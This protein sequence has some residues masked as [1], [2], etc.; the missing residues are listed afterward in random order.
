FR[1]AGDRI[2]H[3]GTLND[4]PG[5]DHMGN[6]AR[7]LRA[8]PGTVEIDVDERKNTGTFIAR[9]KLPEGDYVLEL[10][11]FHEFS[12]CQDGGIVAYLHEHGDSGCGD[13]NWPK[14]FVYLAG[15]GF[16][17]ATLNG[18]PLYQDYQVHF[19]V[20]QGIRDRETLKVDYPR[21]GRK[22]EAGEVNP[23]AMQIDFYIRSPE[24]DDRNHPKRKVFDHFFA[25]EVTWK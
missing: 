10:A 15:W 2:H 9:M 1:I 23:A 6:D 21:A 18:R 14:T 8:A 19:M 16:G 24:Q 12:P 11:R 13:A 4:P 22:S 7:S 20:T 5:W 17:S 25:M 3:V